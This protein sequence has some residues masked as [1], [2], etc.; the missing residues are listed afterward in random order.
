[1]GYSQKNN[2]QYTG[3]W[4]GTRMDY[5]FPFSWEFHHPNWRSHIYQRG[6]ST[7][8]QYV[9]GPGVSGLRVDISPKWAI[10][11]EDGPMIPDGWNNQ[12]VYVETGWDPH[13]KGKATTTQSYGWFEPLDFRSETGIIPEVL[14]DRYCL[15]YI[16]LH[17]YLLILLYDC[18]P[19][20]IQRAQNLV[21]THCKVSRGSR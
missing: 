5:E 12:L 11:G 19:V 16:I 13:Q 6:R 17:P 4:F 18:M 7:T 10:S 21:S 20:F 8:N 9:I 3:W 14:S 2:Q 1:M 15:V